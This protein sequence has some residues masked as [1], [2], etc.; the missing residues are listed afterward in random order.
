MAQYGLSTSEG[1]YPPSIKHRLA[2][3]ELSSTELLLQR[4]G[5]VRQDGGLTEQA[6]QFIWDKLGQQFHDE[7]VAVATKLEEAELNNGKK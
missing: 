3:A 7:L 5:L 1:C 2:Q 6:K 4:Q